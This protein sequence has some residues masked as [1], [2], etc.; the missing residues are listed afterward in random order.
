MWRLTEMSIGM[1]LSTDGGPPLASSRGEQQDRR[2]LCG[3][4]RRPQDFAETTAATFRYVMSDT[5]KTGRRN[6]E[7]AE[8]NKSTHPVI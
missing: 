4:R 6:G 2:Q 5:K 7:T 1:G 3:R 8:T